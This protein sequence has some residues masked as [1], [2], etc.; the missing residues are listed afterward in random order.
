MGPAGRASS[1]G[2]VTAILAAESLVFIGVHVKY[3]E[4]TPI[5]MSS[6]LGAGHDI[7]ANGR[8]AVAPIL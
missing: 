7:I 8:F 1:H 2:G 5:I 3:E 6:V 4:T